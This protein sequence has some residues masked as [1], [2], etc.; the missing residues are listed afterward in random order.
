MGP[1]GMNSGRDLHVV[2][3]SQEDRADDW[4]T[5]ETPAWPTQET[6]RDALG[7]LENAGRVAEEAVRAARAEAAQIVAQARGEAH[8][9]REEAREQIV[10][11]R[12]AANRDTEHL[13]HE[14]LGQVENMVLR[15][16]EEVGELERSAAR[17]RSERAAA[18]QAARDMANRLATLVEETDGVSRHGDHRQQP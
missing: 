17:L 15:A 10:Q 3:G 4:A 1:N 8:R 11:E 5:Q 18:T 12:E 6:P 14:R 16:R 7:L 9:L 13:R 2:R